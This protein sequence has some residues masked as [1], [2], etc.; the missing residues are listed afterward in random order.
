ML[1]MVRDKTYLLQLQLFLQSSIK[2]T[3]RNETVIRG[4]VVQARVIKNF[5][6]VRTVSS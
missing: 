6:W 5:S 2:K 4:N 1:Q 3:G